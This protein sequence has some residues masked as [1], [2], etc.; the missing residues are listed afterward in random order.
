MPLKI[1]NGRFARGKG[2]NKKEAKAV[3]KMDKKFYFDALYKRFGAQY[4]N[5]TREQFMEL[6]TSAYGVYCAMKGFRK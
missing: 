4:P 1:I 5:L 2:K 3:H 6:V